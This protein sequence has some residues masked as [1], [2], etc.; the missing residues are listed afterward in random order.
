MADYKYVEL[1]Q[2]NNAIF[3]KLHYIIRDTNAVLGIYRCQICG[4]QCVSTQHHPLP[5]QDHHTHHNRQPI[6]WRLIVAS[7]H[8]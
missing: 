1:R 8:P 6:Q 5:P 2:I 7:T 3:E 4:H